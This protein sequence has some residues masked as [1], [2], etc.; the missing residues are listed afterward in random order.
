MWKKVVCTYIVLVIVFT[1]LIVAV[2]AIPNSA[3]RNNVIV[4]A[5]QIDSEGIFFRVA[6]CPLW[7]ID[8]MTDCMM[9]N[10]NVDAETGSPLHAAM[11]N[12]YGKNFSGNRGYFDM[13]KDTRLLAEKGRGAVAEQ[14]CY[15]R[16]WHGYQVL[17]RP[18]LTVFNYYQIRIINYILLF[19][20]AFVVLFLLWVHYNPPTSILFGVALL[21]FGFPVVP[22]A[23]QFSTCFYIALVAMIYV[24][25]RRPTDKELPIF[26]FVVGAVTSYADFLTTPQITLGLPLAVV[27]IGGFKEFKGFK[28]LILPMLFWFVGYSSLWATKW[29]LAD[30]FTDGDIWGSVAGNIALRTSSTVITGGVETSIWTLLADNVMLILAALIVVTI[31]CLYVYCKRSYIKDYG[32]LL[33]VALIVPLWFIL[34]KNHSIQHIFFT[35]RAW[36]VTFYAFS[37]FVLLTIKFKRQ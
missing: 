11:V 22:L 33:T 26:F 34:L 14:F 20:L 28:R 25:K 3:V 24:V 8:N 21:L 37:L 15:A 6:G 10:M 23:I 19:S 12:E 17:L 9:L 16:Y 5:E 36:I 29:V 27:V 35:W 32:A 31:P 2:F 4:S 13:A 7:Q 18:L 1:S 30:V